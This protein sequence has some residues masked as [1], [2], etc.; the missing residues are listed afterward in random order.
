M[1]AVYLS[2]YNPPPNRF[3]RVPSATCVR[4]LSGIRKSVSQISGTVLSTYKSFLKVKVG[5]G[6]GSCSGMVCGQGDSRWCRKSSA[7]GWIRVSDSKNN[8]R[9]RR[10]CQ[11][12]L[13]ARFLI[14]FSATEIVSLVLPGS[15]EGC[16]HDGEDQTVQVYIHVTCYND[17]CVLEVL[18]STNKA[19]VEY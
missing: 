14:R 3:I 19:S 6:A 5:E 13:D 2:R 18:D 7:V 12:R 17:T 16:L 15:G 1:I 11:K 4:V 9:A 10:V 8:V